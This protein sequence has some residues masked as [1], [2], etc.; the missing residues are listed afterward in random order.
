[1]GTVSV[2]QHLAV[3]A[4]AIADARRLVLDHSVAV[5][6]DMVGTCRGLVD[7]VDV[8]C[9]ML[10]GRF[11]ETDNGIGH[12][13]DV[14]VWLGVHTNSRQ[15]EGA[16]RLAH[17]SVLS[18][19]PLI[20]AAIAD[21]S[22]GVVHLRMFV[23]VFTTAR[24]EL[25]TR[26]E[27][28]LVS[29]AVELSIP[30]FQQVLRQWVSLCDDELGNPAGDDIAHTKRT[31]RLHPLPDGSWAINGILDTIGGEAV[32]TAIQAAMA[33]PTNDDTRTIG[34]RRHDALVD[35]AHESLA[36]SKRPTIGGE[37]PHVSLIIPVDN[38]HARTQGGGL[39]VNHVTQAMITCDC[40][41]TSI[42][43]FPTGIPFEVGDPETAIP[44][45]TRR[46]VIARDHT[47]R[48]PNCTHPARWTDIHHIKHRK[49]GGNNELGNLVLLCRY[50]HRLIHRM[51]LILA[52]DTDNITLT[53]EWPDG[54]KTNS[55]PTPTLRTA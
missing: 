30:Q 2:E 53:I 44:I 19:F 13:R 28:V 15:S 24:A 3:A 48:Y 38:A 18:S 6:S 8:L 11:D 14:G 1:M 23:A 12:A 29:A 7:Q 42:F 10:V 36:N 40:T 27:E 49:H 34:Q 47:C 54:T 52:W 17:A 45:R 4:T 20:A 26:D 22:I 33:T 32:N 21:G 31:L 46:A 43:T 50:H 37:R 16:T 51:A 25:A 35:I 41:T 39:Y 55:P 9:S 5:S